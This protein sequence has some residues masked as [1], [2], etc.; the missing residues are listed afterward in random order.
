MRQL[1]QF[2]LHIRSNVIISSAKAPHW[3][4]SSPIAAGQFLIIGVKIFG[5]ETALDS[6]KRVYARPFKKF[7]PFRVEE[8]VP[9]NGT[10]MDCRAIICHIGGSLA[11]GHFI[12]YVRSATTWM[13][14]NDDRVTPIADW[15]AVMKHLNS[16]RSTLQHWNAEIP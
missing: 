13:L 7:D 4:N 9:C 5:T 6:A 8:R 11:S 14:I 10:A 15:S 2:S 16:R 1:G 12:T 3:K